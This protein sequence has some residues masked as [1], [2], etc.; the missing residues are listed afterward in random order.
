MGG[1]GFQQTTS[2]PTS[3]LSKGISLTSITMKDSGEHSTDALCTSSLP[4]GLCKAL[5]EERY[6]DVT[7]TCG[8]RDFKVH[9]LVVC[10]QSAWFDLA[11][12]TPPKKRTI[13]NVEIK[14]V[15]PDVFQRFIEFLY[16]GTYTLD[17][18]TPAQKVAS[19]KAEEIEARL[20]H[21]PGCALPAA[22][23]EPEQ[24]QVD[25]PKRSVRRSTRLNST[26]SSTGETPAQRQQHE[27]PPLQAIEMALKLYQVA[28]TYGVRALQLLTRDRF[29]IAGNRRWVTASWASYESTSE[30]EE[31]LLDI[32]AIQD[33]DP[34]WQAVIMM[35]KSKVER[36][37][38]K[39]RMKQ[40][41]IEHP[42]LANC[43]VEH[44]LGTAD[45]ITVAGN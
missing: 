28:V 36:D 42:D 14:N 44:M 27:K 15:E 31:I 34:L 30:F 2:S 11:F 7:I 29:Y 17:G 43:L 37:E 41:T 33:A 12:T 4:S 19:L 3:H 23:P 21:L 40:M 24:M 9:R 32:Y 5:I 38:M 22:E 10:T 45:E 26:T 6:P 25:S 16:T 1:L 18:D 20:K 35:I 8:N 13:K 39:K